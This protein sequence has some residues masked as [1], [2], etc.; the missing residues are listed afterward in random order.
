MEVEA[1]ERKEVTVAMREGEVEMVEA[2][3]EVSSERL[4]GM[5]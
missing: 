4:E 2:V 5:V 3:T 1:E